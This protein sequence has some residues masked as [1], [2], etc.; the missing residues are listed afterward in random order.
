MTSGNYI[1]S[2]VRKYKKGDVDVNVSI[3][4]NAKLKPMIKAWAGENLIDNIDYSGSTAKGTATTFSSDVDV[5]IPLG[6]KNGITLETYYEGIYNLFY[7]YNPRKQNVSVRVKYFGHDIDIVPGRQIAGYTNYFSLFKSKTKSWVQTN[8]Y[9][10]IKLIKDS[11]RVNEIIAVKVWRDLHKLEFSSTLLEH[12]VI[13]ALK[14]H[15]KDD[16]DRNFL[17][18]LEFLRDEIEKIKIIDPSNSNNILSDELTVS[19]KKIIANKAKESLSS[20]EWNKIIW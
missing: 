2:I 6:Y 14:H 19:E 10:N 13:E 11:G 3:F 20:K 9:S 17:R 8:V 1:S 5:F 7:A 18:V 16:Y 15:K 12:I 4:M